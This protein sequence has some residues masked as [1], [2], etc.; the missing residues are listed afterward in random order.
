[1]A[2]QP[3]PAKVVKEILDFHNTLI[4]FISAL[5]EGGFFP[6]DKRQAVSDAMYILEKPWKW[7]TELAEW[8]VLGYP[9]SYNPNYVED[10]ELD[11]S[12]AK[13]LSFFSR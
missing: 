8:E 1:M 12:D 3:V 4:S 5:S 6:N 7:Q 10:L 13:I 9:D 2:E 11:I